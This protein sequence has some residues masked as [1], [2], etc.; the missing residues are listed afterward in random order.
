FFDST[1]NQWGH[2]GFGETRARTARGREHVK[3]GIGF[4]AASFNPCKET[5]DT[6]RTAETCGRIRHTR[7]EI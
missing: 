4:A 2:Q 1:Q 7:G 6:T 5:P 3:R